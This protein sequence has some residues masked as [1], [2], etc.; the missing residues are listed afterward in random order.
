MTTS[1]WRTRVVRSGRRTTWADEWHS[2]VWPVS[3]WESGRTD[4]IDCRAKEE[5]GI[6]IDPDEGEER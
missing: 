1:L 2:T 6:S 4:E 5:N 3:G